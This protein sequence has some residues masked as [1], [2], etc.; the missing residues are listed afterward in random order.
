LNPRNQLP[1]VVQVAM[2]AIDEPG[3]ELLADKF[4]S[5]PFL[6]INYS[7]LFRNPSMLED[8]PATAAPGDGDLAKLEAILAAK[9]ISYRIFS[10][11][12]SIRGAK[13][14]RSQKN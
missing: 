4:G 9:R 8:N 1:P 5:D 7:T 12:V 6:G 14:S 10:T 3:A 2:V 11:N 13:W